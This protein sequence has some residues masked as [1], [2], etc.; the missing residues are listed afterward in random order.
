MV[1]RAGVG[2]VVSER[3]RKAAAAKTRQRVTVFGKRMLLGIVAI[4]VVSVFSGGA[5]RQTNKYPSLRSFLESSN[6]AAKD[7][8]RGDVQAACADPHRW[9]NPAGHDLLSELPGFGTHNASMLWGTYRP[10]VYFG[11][12]TRTSPLAVTGGL[13]WHGGDGRSAEALRHEC[14]EGDGLG[15][16]G[17]VEHDGRS[18]GKQDIQDTKAGIR[19]V[20]SM[21]KPAQ[22]DQHGSGSAAVDGGAAEV[23]LASRIQL[24]PIGTVTTGPGVAPRRASIYF[25]IG[26]DCGDADA[27][28]EGSSCLEAG[29]KNGGGLDVV[30]DGSEESSRRSLLVRGGH[31]QHGGF[32]LEATVAPTRESGEASSPGGGGDGGLTF[33]FVGKRGAPIA[34]IK[35][36]VEKMHEA[37]RRMSRRG[38]K[39]EGLETRP[40]VLP[41]QADVGSDLVLVQVTGTPPFAVDLVVRGSSAGQDGD[42]PP[43]TSDAAAAAAARPFVSSAA[44]SDWLENGSR[45]FSERFRG[46]FSLEDK[47]F[48]DRDVAAAQAALSNM[49]GGMG[50]FTGKSEVRGAGRNGENGFS[51]G[52]SL[53]TAVP[54]RSFFPRGFLWDEGFHQLL[55]SAWD[56]STSV[57]VLGHWLSMMHVHDTEAGGAAGAGCS[58]GWLPR[59]QILGEEARRRVPAAFMAQDISVAN[60]PTLLLLV[61]SLLLSLPDPASGEDTAPSAEVCAEGAAGDK[62]A[63]PQD[64][65]TAAVEGIQ[66]MGLESFLRKAYPLLDLWMRWLLITQRP[67]ATGWGGQAKGAPLGAFQWRGRDPDDDRLNALTLASGLDD[68]PRA[69]HPS[70]TD[71][72]HVDVSSWLALGCRVMQRLSVAIG[73]EGGVPYGDLFEELLGGI[74]ELHWEQEEEAFFDR[75]LHVPDGQ[76]VEEVIMRCRNA[77]GSIQ[78]KGVPLTDVQARKA[79]CAPGQQHMYPLGDGRGGLLTRRRWQGSSPRPQHVQHIGYVSIFPLLLKL[80]PPE[81]PAVGSLLAHMRDSTQLWSPHGLRSLS[82]SDPF[83]QVENNP[84]DEPYWRG[85][86]WV[87]VNYLALAALRHYSQAEGPFRKDAGRIYSE[88]RTNLLRTLLGG[89]RSTGY[90]WE[91]YDDRSGRGLRSH[92]FTGWTALRANEEERS[93]EAFNMPASVKSPVFTSMVHRKVQPQ[94]SWQ[95]DLNGDDFGLD[96]TELSGITGFLMNEVPDN[97]GHFYPPW[98][99]DPAPPVKDEPFMMASAPQSAARPLQQAQIPSPD[100]LPVAPAAD[101]VLDVV[102]GG[103]TGSG[104]PSTTTRLPPKPAKAAPSPAGMARGG[105]GRGVGATLRKTAAGGVTRRRSSSKEEQAKKRRERNRVLARRTR[106]RK[107]FFFQSLQQQV[108]CLQRENERLKSIVSTRCPGTAGDILMS[109]ASKMPSMVADSAGQATALLDQSGFLLVKALQSSQPSFCVTDPQ[110]PDNPIVYASDSFIE[111]TGYSRAQVLGRNCR[112]LQGPDTDPDAV[113]KIRKGIEE[114]SDTSVYLRQYKADGTVFWNHVFVAALRNSED[115]I[116]NYVGIQHPLDKE[117]SPEVVACINNGEE[118]EQESAQEDERQMG[119]DGQWQEGGSGDL[120]QLD[121]FMASEW[122]T[123]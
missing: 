24:F 115:K 117:P 114:G 97:L 38:K 66:D 44:V 62:A 31:P 20:T 49:L 87:N 79:V 14:N 4:A 35:Q 50:H 25:Y 77:D 8:I 34:D 93:N 9:L 40:F 46:T 122:G 7:A 81:S 23:H 56:R 36:E 59:E 88:L 101:P 96:L 121:H 92:P 75:G 104:A 28:G 37:H 12:K 45:S 55:V 15:P 80:L 90:F 78:D 118:Q 51:F 21:V 113:A 39:K 76:L 112:F 107:K 100:P 6:T 65:P 82:A 111:L 98:A 119:L 110:L 72:Y 73:V 22:L 48:E 69:S 57:D 11:F 27:G 10:G 3:K 84:G 106:L 70:E 91:Q 94:T 1:S 5:G 47:G 85:H 58:G 42:Q 67:G 29:G 19:L 32:E 105:A 68:Y 30:H 103:T 123:D 17:W 13:L 116:I 95:D 86:I 43:P 52:A 71:E 33:A 41:N 61:D 53:F 63:S 54:S 2:T 64:R 83:Y 109:C 26:L 89:Y 74:F 60:P 99:N 120:A 16:Y 108:A 102:M 18:Y